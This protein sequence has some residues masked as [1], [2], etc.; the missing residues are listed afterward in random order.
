MGIKFTRLAPN[1]RTWQFFFLEPRC[2]G[3]ANRTRARDTFDHHY[4]HNWAWSNRGSHWV[5][6]ELCQLVLRFNTPRHCRPRGCVSHGV[7]SGGLVPACPQGPIVSSYRSPGY[8]GWMWAVLWM[9]NSWWLHILLRCYMNTGKR[10]SLNLVS[11]N[12]DLNWIEVKCIWEKYVD[13]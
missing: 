6:A 12:L 8:S 1:R 3:G 9:A 5:C 11:G 10:R 4:V 2:N 13:K 7:R